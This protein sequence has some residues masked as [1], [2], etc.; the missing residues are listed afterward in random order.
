MREFRAGA[1]P[2]WADT[3]DTNDLSANF[4]LELSSETKSG[5]FQI[6]G[7][8][9]ILQGKDA[10]S[11]LSIW[12]ACLHRAGFDIHYTDVRSV[13]YLIEDRKHPLRSLEGDR[14][15]ARADV[16]LI[17]DVL[18]EEA[19]N[20]LSEEQRASV[21]WYLRAAMEDGIVFILA[22]EED[23]VGTTGMPMSFGV[24]L[25]NN[26]QVIT[27]SKKTIKKKTRK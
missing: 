10:R 12:S 15:F 13:A 14:S 24:L 6:G 3:K 21:T 4:A 5:N 17:Q 1:V 16:L 22:T 18:N 7:Q 23:V 11:A 26:F 8:S 20:S 27:A 25:E 9:L 2:L 19:V